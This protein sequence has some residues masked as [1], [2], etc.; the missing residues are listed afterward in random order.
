MTGSKS[1]VV[2]L[3]LPSDDPKKRNPD[4]SKAKKYLG[5]EPRFSLEEGLKET[6]HYFREL[7]TEQN[8]A[9]QTKQE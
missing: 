4:I 7:H 5:W 9:E 1:E 8:K 3:E 6:I 2:Y